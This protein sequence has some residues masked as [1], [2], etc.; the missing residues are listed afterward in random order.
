MVIHIPLDLIAFQKTGFR[1]RD[2]DDIIWLVHIDIQ[3]WECRSDDS[4]AA[5]TTDCLADLFRGGYS[6]SKVIIFIF[7]NVGNESGWNARLTAT[8]NTLKIPVTGK[9]S[10]FHQTTVV[11]KSRIR[12]SPR[13]IE[14]ASS[15]YALFDPPPLTVRPAQRGSCLSGR[16][17]HFL[18]N[19]RKTTAMSGLRF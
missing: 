5:I 12:S 18:S 2:E 17:S 14:S 10:N 19:K 13:K 7:Q 4:A 9:G 11:V 16:K 8:V 3:M 6:D 15:I 1:S